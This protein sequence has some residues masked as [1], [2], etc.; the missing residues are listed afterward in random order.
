[1]TKCIFI[2]MRNKLHTDIVEPGDTGKALSG[3]VKIHQT[4]NHQQCYTSC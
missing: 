3:E 1:M 4:L 2:A